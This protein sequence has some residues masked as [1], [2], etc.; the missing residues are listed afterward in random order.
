LPEPEPRPQLGEFIA[1]EFD[2]E[3]EIGVAGGV[4]VKVAVFLP[5]VAVGELQGAAVSLVGGRLGVRRIVRKVE[6]RQWGVAGAGVSGEEE[7]RL[8]LLLAGV[9][10]LE[11]GVGDPTIVSIYRGRLR[12]I[13]LADDLDEALAGVDLVA[14]DLAQVAWP[15]AKG[16]LK[17][18]RVAQSCKDG[19]DAAA[20]LA[21]LRR[22][23]GDKDG[24]LVHGTG[25]TKNWCRNEE[26]SSHTAARPHQNDVKRSA[27]I[28]PISL[29]NGAGVTIIPGETVLTRTGDNSSARP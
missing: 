7:P 24:R 14:Q 2:L 6:A 22:D 15:G 23:A 19:G 17:D 5:L 27:D 16:F 21:K 12:P 11:L 1:E 28:P 9:E 4:V 18:G 25:A 10:E 3:F 13:A 29:S 20:Y 26:M 8:F